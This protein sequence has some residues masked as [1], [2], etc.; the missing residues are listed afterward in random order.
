MLGVEGADQPVFLC[1][2]AIFA[3][4]AVEP[5]KKHKTDAS[6]VE[7]GRKRAEALFLSGSVVDI[8]FKHARQSIASDAAFELQLVE[9]A[10]RVAGSS[11]VASQASVLHSIVERT[12]A[13][14]TARYPRVR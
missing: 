13:D 6:E 2:G 11:T 4:A 8:V 14:I 7:T 9:T 12:L 5:K 3:C 10:D 1:R